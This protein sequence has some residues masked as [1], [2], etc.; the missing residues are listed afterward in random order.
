MT[1]M[2]DALFALLDPGEEVSFWRSD[3][4]RW[5]VDVAWI[6]G[7]GSSPGEAVDDAL[8]LLGKKL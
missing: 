8:R 7:E 3:D 4:G 2:F 5:F 1:T 6:R